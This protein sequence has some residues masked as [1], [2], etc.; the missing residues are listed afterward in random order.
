MARVYSNS[1]V[2]QALDAALLFS[3]R[4]GVPSMGFRR[5]VEH[6][7][8]HQCGFHAGLSIHR[9]LSSIRISE[10]EELRFTSPVSRVKVR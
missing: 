9:R 3:M 10:W 8:M 1:T 4:A 7:L 6:R 2:T 5:E